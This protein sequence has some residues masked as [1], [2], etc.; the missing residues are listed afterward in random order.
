MNGPI[1]VTGAT[2]F[3]GRALASRLRR[4]GVALRCLVRDRARTQTTGLAP[5]EIVEGSLEDEAALR[6]AVTGVEAVVH[7]AGATR[8]LRAAGFFRANTEGSARLAAA[9]AGCSPGLR[10]VH[11]SSLA[12]AGPSVDGRGSDAAPDACRPRSCYGRSKLG[13]E[14]GVLVHASRIDWCIVRPPIVYGP[15]DEAT[16]LLVAQAS[17]WLAPVPLGR[18]PLSLVH[19]DDLV[20]ALIFALESRGVPGFF[21]IDGPERADTTS[22]PQRIAAVAGRRVRPLPV[23][24]PLA[25]V[26]GFAA[27][28]VHRLT[29]VPG[30]FGVD[31]LRDVASVGWVADPAPAR[32]R[33]GFTARIGIDDGFRSTLAAIR[34]SG[35]D[36]VT[37]A[38]G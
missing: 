29:G 10:F 23:P 9:A 1:L 24:M 4:D 34:P 12:A 25:F 32:E 21:P 18:R 6:R 26:A 30:Y 14:R 17:G 13:G 31:K 33:L 8:A 5:S 35:V 22:L 15:G 16:A 3:I 19:V 28:L 36:P 11:V 20:T 37:R 7:L 27:D 38:G 2:G